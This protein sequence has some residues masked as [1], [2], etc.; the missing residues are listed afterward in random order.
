[1]TSAA[2]QWGVDFA[3]VREMLDSLSGTGDEWQASKL[4][5]SVE[6]LSERL[7]LMERRPVDF[8]VGHG[9]L[10]RRRAALDTLRREVGTVRGSMGGGRGG[11]A[12]A[13]GAAG[14]SGGMS[15]LEQQRETMKEHD[16]M[17]ADLGRGVGRLKTQSVMIN[18]ET[19]LHVRLLDDME[20]DAER[21]SSGLLTEARHAEKI[22]EKSKTFNLYVIILVLSIILA[23]LVFSGL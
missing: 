22:R 17:L 18:E 9:E 6:A 15:R 2:Q 3:R 1:M 5:E 8:A 14:G 20:G 16:R 7:A 13:A 11:G 4:G 21:A 23:I 10:A 12:A 19:S